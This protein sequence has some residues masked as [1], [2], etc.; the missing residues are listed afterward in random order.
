VSILGFYGAETGGTPLDD[1]CLVSGANISSDW[2]H[3][4]DYSYKVD[5]P[6]GTDLCY[7]S[8]MTVD[9][10]GNLAYVNTT[11]TYFSFYFYIDP[12]VGIPLADEMIVRVLNILGNQM[13]ELRIKTTGVIELFNGPGTLVGTTTAVLTPGV[14]YCISGYVSKGSAAA[15]TVD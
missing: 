2:V 14:S 8:Q 5:R 1:G 6:A 7:F 3:S 9:S 13:A 12:T 11:D 15:W 4:G 10:A